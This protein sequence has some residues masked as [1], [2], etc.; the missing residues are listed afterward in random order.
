MTQTATTSTQFDIE[1]MTCASCV[2]RI[3]KSLRKVPGVITATVNLATERASIEALQGQVETHHLVGAIQAAGY[4]ARA[5]ADS[6]QK[7]PEAKSHGLWTV[8]V[9]VFL[10]APLVAPMLVAPFCLEMIIPGW[11]QLALATPI[12]FWLGFRFYRNGWK[13]LR[14]GSGN[15]DLL[16]AI[17]TTAAYALS[18]YLL[19]DYG[20]FSDHNVH[21]YFESSVVIIT[22]VLLGK[23]LEAITEQQTT[24]AIR[25]LNAL[26]PDTARLRRNYKKPEEML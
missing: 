5:T 14:S 13:A 17:G 22:L 21:L 20:F 12:Q 10:S 16:V 4:K 11:L 25:A 19:L 18:L 6:P 3:E 9:A 26:R 8:I 15:M 7:R 1:G 2:N 24:A 23:W